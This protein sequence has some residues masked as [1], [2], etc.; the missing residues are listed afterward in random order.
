MNK[1]IYIL[2]SILSLLSC[3]DR[4]GSNT[5]SAVSSTITDSTTHTDGTDSIIV[6]PNS[7]DEVTT[8]SDSIIDGHILM[9]VTYRIW[10][11]D[12][13]SKIISK[14]WLELH[15]KNNAYYVTPASYTIEYNDEEPCSG[16]PTETITPNENVLVF[17]DLPTIQKG[18]VDSVAF[19][20]AVVEPGKPFDFHL[21][22]QRYQLIA[23][24]IQFYKDE[25]RNNPN[26]KYVLKL[27]KGDHYVKTLIHQTSYNDTATEIKFIG[28]LDGDG[29]PDFIFSSPR[30][31]EEMRMIII[32]SRSATAYE[33]TMQFDC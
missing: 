30:D 8:L 3:Q 18:K 15:H 31:Y 4:T 9:P 16:L 6:S 11:G 5:G 10:E 2:L 29:E 32:L 33:G 22:N 17:F 27:F 20:N 1:H 24:G 13:V 23:S 19:N 7:R 14:Q 28:D 12:A 25:N 21:K 26:A